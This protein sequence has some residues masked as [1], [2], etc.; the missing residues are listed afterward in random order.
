[1]AALEEVFA[2][3]MP[4]NMAF[5]YTGMSYQEKQAA[6]GIPIYE[7]FYEGDMK[8]LPLKRWDRLGANAAFLNLEGAGDSN[9][10]YVAEIPTGASTKPMRH[11]YEELIYVLQGTGAT[12]M[13]GTRISP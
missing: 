6:E 9:N 13:T 10:C 11:I 12:T 1:M 3:T 4:S 7:T 5:D 2:Q 8:T